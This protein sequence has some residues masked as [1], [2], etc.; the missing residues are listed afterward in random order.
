MSEMDEI[1]SRRMFLD[2]CIG[3]E[4]HCAELYHYYSELY[5]HIPDIALLWKKSALEEESHRKQFELALLLL[6]E[7]E[8]EV[9]K[10]CLKRAFY[11][12]DKIQKLTEQ[13]KNN[14][15]E[16]ITAISNAV[17]LEEKLADLHVHTALRFKEESMQKLFK[18]MGEADCDH[19][20]ALQQYRTVLSLS[21]SPMGE[22]QL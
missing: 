17:E 1:M 12:K 22:K 14:R 2:I 18:T 10:E 11:I 19:V 7:A 21:L 5:E 4:G 8:Y 9:P 13:V 3:I 6:N 20:A 16:L 15:P